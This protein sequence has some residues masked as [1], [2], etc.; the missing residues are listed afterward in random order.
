MNVIRSA[1]IAGVVQILAVWALLSCVT[2]LPTP[3]VPT[4]SPNPDAAGDIFTGATIDC[5]IEAMNP[6]VDEVRTCGD[7]AN[8]DSCLV[9]LV[10]DT[11]TVDVIG[12]TVRSLG[13]TL[14]VNKTR[15]T[16]SEAEVAEVSA[17][18][19]WFRTHNISIRE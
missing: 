7:V 8:T 10:S 17:F 6:P 15:G 19:R 14:H 1:A 3:P 16:A 5:S 2:P 4:P 12:C 9:N 11:R 13:M 18:D